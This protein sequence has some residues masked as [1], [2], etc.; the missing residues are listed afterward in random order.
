MFW[1]NKSWLLWKLVSLKI[2]VKGIGQKLELVPSVWVD[3]LFL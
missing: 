3:Q 2:L 1:E